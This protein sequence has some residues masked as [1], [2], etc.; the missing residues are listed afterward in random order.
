MNGVLRA[1]DAS[2]ELVDSGLITE[3]EKN[4]LLDLP[5]PDHFLVVRTDAHGDYSRY[6]LHLVLSPTSEKPPTDFDPILSQ[7]DFSFKVEC[8][9]EFDC[10]AEE[11]CP[12]E[13]LDEP[14]IDY[15]AKD[16]AGFRKLMLDRLSV[17]LPDWQERSPADIGI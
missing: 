7:V 14:I 10:E 1:S 8:P 4:L 2:D 9:S 3:E 11:V 17:V 13:P 12:P 16:Y 5:K 15:L 6:T